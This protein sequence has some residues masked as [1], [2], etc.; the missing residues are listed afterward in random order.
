MRYTALVFYQGNVFAECEEKH[1]AIAKLVYI[2]LRITN[3]TLEIEI[4]NLV[5]KYLT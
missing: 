1:D 4:G 2:L 3:Y 5:M